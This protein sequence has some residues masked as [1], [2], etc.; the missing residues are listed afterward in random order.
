MYIKGLQKVT[1]LDYPGKVACTIFTYGCNFRCPFCQNS[2]LVLSKYAGD[3]ISEK[4]VYAYLKKRQGLLDGVCISGGEPTLQ[5]DLEEFIIRIKNMNYRVKL[6]TN[7]YRPEIM[8]KLIDKSLIDYIA[9][10]IKT[11][12]DRYEVVSGI[13]GI[14]FDTIN[15]SIKIIRS[16]DIEHEFRTTVVNELHSVEDFKLIGQL[17]AG[18]KRYFLQMFTDSGEILCSGLTAP[19]EE[20]MHE[21]LYE[22]R[23]FIPDAHLRGI[24]E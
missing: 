16:S 24:D 3:Y 21:Y 5:V 14:N 9:M 8:K 1:L 22:V 12:P 17:L 19:S 7:G 23:K 11:S 15:E 13:K 2:E 18:E 6:D 10:D 4:E 20:S